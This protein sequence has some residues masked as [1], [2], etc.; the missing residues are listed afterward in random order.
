M[1][2]QF[3]QVLAMTV[4]MNAGKMFPTFFYSGEAS[5]RERI[6]SSACLLPI[7]LA[8]SLNFRIRSYIMDRDNR[9][10]YILSRTCCQPATDIDVVYLQAL[11]IG[12]WPRG[13]VGAGII[14]VAIG[15]NISG[16]CVL[17]SAITLVVNLI[18][19]GK[20]GSN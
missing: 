18:L 5:L 15:L 8:L 7:C 4:M 2:P 1:C 12:I 11:G 9:Q 6:V 20:Q 17:V 10:N 19:I 3:R 16:L 13:E 14:I